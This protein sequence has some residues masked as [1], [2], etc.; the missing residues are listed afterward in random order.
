MQDRNPVEATLDAVRTRII[1][2]HR[3]KEPASASGRQTVTPPLVRLFFDHP[4]VAYVK[5]ALN[6]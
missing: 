4:A 6:W 2:D 3:S 5:K 1:D